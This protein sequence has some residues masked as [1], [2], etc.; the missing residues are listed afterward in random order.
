MD[1]IYITGHRNPDTDS[2]VSALAYAALR[3]AVGDRQYQAARL[4]PVSDETKLVLNRFG[5]E[6]PVLITNLRTQVQD[7][8]FDTPPGLSPAATVSRAWDVMKKDKIRI[9]PIQNED[10]TLYGMLSAGDVANYDV[11]SVRDPYV[12]DIPIYNLLSVLEGRV[13]NKSGEMKDTISGEVTIALPAG[14][15]NLMFSK[16]DSIVVCG[17][18]PEMIR[19]ALE[20]NV[21]CVVVCQAEVSQDLLD[22]ESDTCIIATPYDAYRAVR[23]ICHAHPISGICKSE[24]LVYFHLTDYID[25]VR[26]AVLESR[27]RAYPIL[28]ENECVVGTLSRYHLLRPR[29]KRVVLVDHNERAQ[30]VEGLEQ[31]ELLEIIDHHRL[32]DIETMH[33]IYMRN[34]PVGSTATIVAGMYQERGLLPSEKIAGLLA[35]AIVSDTVMF[36]SPTCTQRDI[37]VANRMARIANQSLEELGKAIFSASCGD[38]KTVEAMLNTDYKEFNLSG[39]SVAVSQIT[40]MDSERL[41]KRKEEFLETM[42]AVRK[43][44]DLEMVLLMIT[45]VL[46]DGTQLLFVGDENAIRKAFNAKIEEPNCAFLPKIMS[47]KKQTI[48]MLSNLWA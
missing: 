48:P 21:N 1:T 44:R 23:L 34:E 4:G 47:R 16:Q 41:L 13:I 7:L 12:K 46:L 8:D 2:I 22:M 35:S 32:A 11:E 6:P 28:D 19:R 25:D 15:E 20:L 14:R 18:Q 42:E 45:D 36:K 10:G 27:F 3:N 9:M 33:P 31:A 39:H 40:C 17:D 26:E 38:D 37:D 43:K 29:R 30:S 5:V 24:N